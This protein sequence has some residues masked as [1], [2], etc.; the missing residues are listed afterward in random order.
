MDGHRALD[1]GW[2]P[3]LY[4][5]ELL[6]RGAA[7]VAVDVTPDFVEITQRRLSDRAAVLCADLT[8]PLDFAGDAA[9]D[10]VLCPLVLDYIEDW[11]AVFTEFGRVLKSGGWLMF[12]CGHPM[13][14]FLYFDRHGLT[15]D[16]FQIQQ[17]DMR[18][19]SFGDPASVIRSYRRPLGTVLNPLIQAGFNLERLL[20]PLPTEAFRQADPEGYAQLLHA[21]AFLGVR[22]HTPG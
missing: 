8:R 15:A 17:F 16:Y 5:E 20:E 13:G 9:F 12:S 18:W 21:P 2:A 22:A 14:D 6:R 1:A 19:A 3:R 4:T 7:V 11:A 10:G